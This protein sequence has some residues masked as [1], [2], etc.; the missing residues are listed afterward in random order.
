MKLNQYGAIGLVAVIVIAVLVL[1][2]LVALRPESAE[3]LNENNT[4]LQAE[5]NDTLTKVEF[6]KIEFELEEIYAE[7]GTY[8]SNE[9]FPELQLDGEF[10]IY[11]SRDNI[12]DYTAYP[13][14]CD[15]VQVEC[16]RYELSADLEF[17]GIGDDDEDGNLVDEYRASL[18]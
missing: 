1:V 7:K 16:N 8:P 14:G 6:E 17:D 3:L 10:D 9:K 13:V 12:Y 18:N 2:V 11:D 15:N 4:S 5:A